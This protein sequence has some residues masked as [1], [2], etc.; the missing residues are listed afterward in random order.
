MAF[1][2]KASDAV[3]VKKSSFRREFGLY[4]LLYLIFFSIVFLPVILRD[5]LIL[6]GDGYGMYYPTLVNFRRSL[7]D[8]GGS[9]KNGSFQF[10]MMNFNYGPGTDNLTALVAFISCPVYYFC[11]LVPVRHLA[12][13]MTVTIFLLDYIAGIAFLRLCSHFGHQTYWNS[14]MAL[15][16]VFS[17]CFIDNYLYNP[18]FMY[19]LIAFP[20]MV[21]GI[22]RVICKKGWRLLCFCVFWIGLSSFTMLIY[23]LPFLALFAFVRVAFVYKEHFVPNLLKAFLRCLPV[24]ITGFLLAA[25]MQLPV[26]NLLI[27]SARSVGNPNLNYAKLLIPSLSR[28]SEC[29]FMIEPTLWRLPLN[30]TPM[31]IAFPGILLT[32]LVL[33]QHTELRIHMLVAIACVSIP[34]ID[35][36]LNSFQYSLIRWGCA[37][38]LILAFAGSVGMSEFR[39][40]DRSRYRRFILILCGY[41]ISASATLFLKYDV[42][43]YYVGLIFAAAVLR[44]IPPVC[45]AW[46]R[47][48][49]AAWNK[50]RQFAALLKEKGPSVRRYAAF[51]GL[52]VGI[53]AVM[54]LSVILIFLPQYAFHAQLVV[55]AVI[56]AAVSA[57]LMKKQN[58]GKVCTAVLAVC[59]FAGAI[60]LY[61]PVHN[62]SSEKIRINNT[63]QMLLEQEAQ[64]DTFGRNLYLLTGSNTTGSDSDTEDSSEAPAELSD[65]LQSNEFIEVAEKSSWFRFR[66]LFC[67]T[68]DNTESLRNHSLI[69]N[70]PNLY[71]F[72]NMIDSDLIE[73]ESRTGLTGNTASSLTAISGLDEQEVLY[74]LF[75]IRTI[76]TGNYITSGFGIEE[77]RS[78]K[79]SENETDGI[80]SYRYALPLGVTYDRYMNR[81]SYDALEPAIFPY[82]LMQSAYT[83]TPGQGSI[84]AD[85]VPE[86]DAYRC[87][88]RSEKETLRTNSVGMDV[89]KY[90]LTLDQDVSD[91]FLY[92][93]IT[94][95][96]SHYPPGISNSN[97]YFYVDGVNE[98]RY[99]IMNSDANWP[100]IRHADRYAFPLGYR[101]KPVQK[102]EFELPME[103]EEMSV[104]A[105]PASV[106]TDAYAARCEEALENVQ[107]SMNRIDGDI[108][109]SKD[110][111]LSVSMLHNSGW[112]VFVDGKEAPLCKVNGLFLGVQLPAGTHHVR[113]TYRTPWLTAGLICSGTGILLWITMELI[114]RRKK[115][116]SGKAA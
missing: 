77:I 64:Y 85:T 37:P 84:P 8:F 41:W 88:F 16:Y 51:G 70:F 6:A 23:T 114:T 27:N 59:F 99:Y 65:S 66:D 89:C 39:K 102:I 106:L 40:L 94:G 5:G 44:L 48:T 112:R 47:F 74:S 68:Q 46:Q 73:F 1:F 15:S 38:S 10:P 107:L 90:T 52:A 63:I 34:L 28:M 69:C 108:T 80:Y 71:Y 93:N 115:K 56:T 12:T 58:W 33:K 53:T 20:L 9:I 25:V 97:I 3:P 30:I 109:V 19:M 100:W 81:E 78:E 113:F 91:C 22:D 11:V 82:A 95:C 29:F 110:K 72:H 116:Q 45:R 83:E 54:L 104:Y 18:H 24:L 50:C 32:L 96:A 79:I 62:F 21:I 75:G 92:L 98:K 13:F 49:K 60:V 17:T 4:T 86:Q 103:Y 55:T 111:L 14:L 61:L 101:D 57:V 35:Y 43:D 42:I 67:I 31:F 2:R 26:L 36:G 76:G 7:L 105:I 87:N